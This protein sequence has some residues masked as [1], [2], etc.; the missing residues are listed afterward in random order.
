MMA[1]VDLGL[2]IIG[3][4]GKHVCC[5]DYISA[6]LWEYKYSVDHVM[7]EQGTQD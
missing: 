1:S 3:L 4:G 2:L 7:T 5:L 6:L